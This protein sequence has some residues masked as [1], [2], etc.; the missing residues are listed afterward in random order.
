M[1]V[2]QIWISHLV[3]LSA[4]VLVFSH[5]HAKKE[6]FQMLTLITDRIKLYAPLT[7]ENVDFTAAVILLINRQ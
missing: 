3:F 4:T 2:S 6:Y 7:G 5:T 1:K